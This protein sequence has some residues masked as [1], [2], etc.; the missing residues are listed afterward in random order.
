MA[1]VVIIG[2]GNVGMSFA[3]QLVTH[4]NKV[5]ELVLID[6]NKDK[7]CGEAKDLEHASVY[8]VNNIKIWAGEYKDCDNA[9]IVVITAGKVQDKKQTRADLIKCNAKIME[10]I[11]ESIKKTKFKG[12]YLVVT[13]PVDVMTQV[14]QVA[15]GFPHERVIGSGT[16]LDTARLRHLISQEL[17]I[18]S[19]NIKAY[20]LGEHGDSSFVPWNS[21]SV[22][23]IPIMDKLSCEQ[24]DKVL[25]LTRTE[26]YDIINK[27][28]ST[29]YGIGVCMANIV[30]AILEN[31]QSIRTVSS[32]CEKYG[33]YL[34]QPTIIGQSGVQQILS[35]DLTCDESM[36]MEK[37]A[38]TIRGMLKLL[39]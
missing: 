6:I 28:G 10:S 5:S 35:V 38:E 4:R 17:N 19:R 24:R 16:T 25:Y 3:Y 36:A 8:N 26:A 18:D 34:G 31:S 32:F 1:R 39:R 22:G 29:Y 13:N 30:D 21:C 37:S 11:V 23:L 2:C 7:A 15:S 27:K 9:D 33:V 20:V 12:I 14:V